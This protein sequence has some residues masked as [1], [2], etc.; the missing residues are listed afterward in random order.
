MVNIL[1][2]FATEPCASVVTVR[3]R[4]PVSWLSRT[5]CLLPSLDQSSEFPPQDPPGRRGLSPKLSSC[6]HMHD[7]AF[8]L[9]HGTHR[10]SKVK[11]K[12]IKSK[13]INVCTVS[14]KIE[15]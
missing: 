7:M 8:M 9:R 15:L 4:G 10:G 6:L 5:R 13:K 3:K 14:V 12:K 11:V 1:S 2:V